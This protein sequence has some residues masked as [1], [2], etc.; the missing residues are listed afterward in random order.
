MGLWDRILQ[1]TRIHHIYF[2]L[3]SFD[4]AAVGTGLYLSHHMNGM[5]AAN[6]AANVEWGKLQNDITAV[7]RVAADANAPGN[8][9]FI[10]NDLDTELASWD[11][12]LEAL[13]T[14]IEAMK[15]RALKSVPAEHRPETTAHLEQID[16][17]FDALA[18]T[19]TKLF[20]LFRRGQAEASAPAQTLMNRQ[21]DKLIGEL[22]ELSS[23]LHGLLLNRQKAD[24][25]AGD[26]MQTWEMLL[27]IMAVVMVLTVTLFGHWIGKKSQRQYDELGTA[28]ERQLELMQELSV[29]HDNV[30][31]LNSELDAVNRTLEERIDAR[32]HELSQANDLITDLNVELTN[33]ITR[34]KEAQDEIV[35]RG[36]MAQL[37]QLTATVAH[38][39]RNPLGSI[40]TAAYLVEHKTK[41]HNLGI[42]KQIERINA[43]IHRCD[44]IITQ[45]MDFMR[46][47]GVAATTVTLDEWVRTTLETERHQVA[48]C[49]HLEFEPGAGAARV[50]IDP[51]RMH[52]ML[53]NLILNASEAMVGN[54][55]Y[56]KV[57]ADEEPTIWVATEIDD[58]EAR[59][60]VTDNGPGIS[61]ANLDR[62]LE[63]LF[64]TKSFGVGLG[65]TVAE[66]I[67]RQHGGRLEIDSDEGDGATFVAHFA[68]KTASQ[69]AA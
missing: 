60:V 20:D 42:D 55:E 45:L 59:I 22:D 47:K 57:R 24:V 41:G 16:E 4:V 11:T 63:P 14:R 44:T 54:G 56:L 64:T 6:V 10:S 28:H 48:D 61:E 37:G 39:I 51:E 29:S 12:Q 52:R 43:A 50:E 58:G 17:T 35:R 18:T 8:D 49:I 1:R 62:I 27:G 2:L 19:S 46:T 21:N 40:R 26:A 5:I 7:R 9:L 34:L 67:L 33:G 65:L 38:E 31:A 23:Y 25:A 53:L 30:L 66:E 68:I 69:A 13:E 36:R 15:R 3:A 32:T